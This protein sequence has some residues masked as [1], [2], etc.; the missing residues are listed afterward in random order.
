MQTSSPEVKCP[1]N[2]WL[3]TSNTPW[4]TSV[5][6][7][8]CVR[9]VSTFWGGLPNGTNVGLKSECDHAGGTLINIPTG[10]VGQN[11]SY[12]QYNPLPN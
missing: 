9:R 5:T 8:I 7:P 10:V 11:L 4:V 1:E 12:C 6:T 2:S 3:V